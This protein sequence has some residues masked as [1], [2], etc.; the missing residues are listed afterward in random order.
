MV[1]QWTT[2][3]ESGDVENGVVAVCAVL[4]FLG[5]TRPIYGFCKK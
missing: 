3:P 4:S 5:S 2:P 1:E